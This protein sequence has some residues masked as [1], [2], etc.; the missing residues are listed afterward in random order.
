MN[1]PDQRGLLRVHGLDLSYFT[2]KLEGY[3]R[4]KGLAYE[5]VEMGTRAF[6]RCARITGVAQM[7]QLELPD[8][9]WLTDSTAIIEQFE[10][11]FSEPAIYPSD[12]VLCFI[13]DLLEDFGD[14]WLWRPAMYYRWAFAED[15]RQLSEGLA[16][17]LLRDVPLP[18]VLRRGWIKRRQRRLFLKGDGITR[19]TAPLVEALYPQILA[20]LQS[21]LADRPFLLGLRP[22]Q[23]D[24][25]FFG[26]MFRHFYSDPTGAR[27]MRERAPQVC[28]W[29]ERLW[30]LTP[31]QFTDQPALT[32][33]PEGLESL[34]E[35]LCRD[36][37]PYLQANEQAVER[38]EKHVHWQA[39]GVGFTTPSSPYQ[40]HCWQRL[41]ARFQA[42]QPPQQQ[43]VC[44]WLDDPAVS[45]MLQRAAPDA[46]S[47]APIS[48]KVLD[49]R[50]R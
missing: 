46:C 20:A 19:H 33:I 16:R 22:S 24:M 4:A 40:R 48:R 38:G 18:L 43:Q 47:K 7:P 27:I 9:R 30:H 42:L 21:A 8:G 15:A 14:E 45:A 37:L 11:E 50:W 36:Y 34:R 29:V 31:E 44:A 28:A 3:L 13:A 2:G 12:P 25:G 17:G 26:S 5:L 41:R 23:A 32:R 1:A 39:Q 6:R 10:R 49:Q 35:T